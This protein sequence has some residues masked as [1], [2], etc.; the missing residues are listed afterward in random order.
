MTDDIRPTVL[1]PPAPEAAV[2]IPPEQAVTEEAP[3]PLPPPPPPSRRS[4]VLL[5]ALLGGALAAAGGFALSHYNLL[6]LRGEV[7]PAALEARLT[8]LD[9]AVADTRIAADKAA[10]EARALA[11]ATAAGTGAEALSGEVAALG[12]KL[13][14][15]ESTLAAAATGSGGLSEAAIAQLQAQIDALKSQPAADPEAIRATVQAELEARAGQDAEAAA[16]A[17]EAARLQSAKDAALLTLREA[18]ASGAPYGAALSAM[19]LPQAPEILTQYAESG[20]PTL[21]QL[22]AEF[23]DPARAALDAALRA[24]SGN[25]V[26]SGLWSFLRIQTGA[27]SLTPQEGDDP[28]AVLSRA[29]AAVTAGDLPAAL[30]ELALLPPESQPALADWITRAQDRIAAETAIAG[31]LPPTAP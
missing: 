28:D 17:A 24:E 11:E 14:E 8:A 22:Q 4:G 31:L 13:A 18:M 25:S 19:A 12:A 26:S 9:K 30:T 2:E 15:V 21:A 7:D 10:T 16:Q 5:A 27:R 3:R 23:P 1:Q 29:E 20:L 6:N